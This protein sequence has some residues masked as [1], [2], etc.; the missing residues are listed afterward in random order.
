MESGLKLLPKNVARVLADLDD[1]SSVVTECQAIMAAERPANIAEFAVIL[2][3][4]WLHYPDSAR[5]PQEQKIIAD[6]WRR[7]MGHLPADILQSAADAYVLSPARFSPTPGQLSA[8]AEKAWAYR[9][10]LAGR[11]RETLAL[12]GA[13]VS[14]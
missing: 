3:R 6:D 1:R 13:Q 2:E 10:A 7:L 8:V 9:K 14:A 4:L 11:A 5:A 12:I